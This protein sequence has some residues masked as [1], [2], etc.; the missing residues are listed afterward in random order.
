MMSEPELSPQM[1]DAIIML[2]RAGNHPE[3]ASAVYGVTQEM[4]ERWL[5][6]AEAKIEP[7]SRLKTD[8]EKYREEM[9]DV[10]DKLIR[11]FIEVTN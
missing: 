4:Y 7:Y 11:R 8:I 9:Q 3:T 1:H 5:D 2:V 6:L 10:R